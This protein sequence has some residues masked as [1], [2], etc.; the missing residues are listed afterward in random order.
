MNGNQLKTLHESVESE[1][2]KPRGMDWMT[3]VL[4]PRAS[5]APGARSRRDP[6]RVAS[7]PSSGAYRP[8]YIMVLL[9]LSSGEA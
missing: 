1:V 6:C 9:S 8:D 3:P 7:W 5:A 2:V 4:L